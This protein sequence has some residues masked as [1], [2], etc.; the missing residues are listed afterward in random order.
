M[1]KTFLALALAA[2]SMPAAASA[3]TV[4]I[5][6]SGV[7]AGAGK[8]YVSLQTR[9]QFMKPFGSYGAV[10]AEPAAGS[11][12]VTLGGV[13]P[14]T[15]AAAVWHDVNGNNRWDSDEQGRPLDGWAMLNGGTLR[16]RPTFEQVSFTVG[17]APAALKLDMRYGR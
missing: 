1:T 8:L 6:L 17:E 9:E 15:Y 16:A 12:T 5:D 11:R 14:G 10:V 3:A 4:T 7:R 2:A 13:A